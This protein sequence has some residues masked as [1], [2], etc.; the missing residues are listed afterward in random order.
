MKPVIDPTAHEYINGSEARRVIGCSAA[1]L[2]RAVAFGF[3]GIKLDPGL[4]PRYRRADV[5]R[6]SK[7]RQPAPRFKRQAQAAGA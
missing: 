5:E 2:H 4:T 1:A 3:I 6:Y 7:T